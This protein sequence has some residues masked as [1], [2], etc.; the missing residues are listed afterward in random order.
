MARALPLLTPMRGFAAIIVAFYHARLVLF[1]QWKGSIA[2]HSAFLENGYIWVDLFFML[3]GFVMMHVY[4]KQLGHGLSWRGFVWLRFTRIYPLFFVSFLALFLWESF[5]SSHGLGF[6]GGPLMDAWGVTGMTAFQG[7]FNRSDAIV[8]NL[9]LIQAVSTHSLSWNIASWSLSVEWLVYLLFPLSLPALLKPAKSTMWI[10]VLI[11]V[12]YYSIIDLTGTLDLTAGINAFMRGLCGFVLGCWLYQIRLST[13][14]KKAI[15]NDISLA[16]VCTI[17]LVILHTPLTQSS[18]LFT[19]LSFAL[20]VLIGAHQTPRRTIVFSVLDNRAT[21]Y[22]GD[23][24]YSIYLWHVVIVLAGVELSHYL[25]PETVAAW[26][27]R[28]DTL[29]G[30]LGA[31][32]FIAMTLIISA[33]SYHSIERPALKLLRRLKQTSLRSVSQ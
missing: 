32:V 13:P 16:I 2:D 28:T 22:L 21:R 27:S 23:I 12:L 8:D 7:P 29:S 31:S 9:L 17:P 26:F 5:K 10:P 30:V 19:L 6:Y 18:I 15:D 11:F 14:L 4:R 33:L 1:P 24:S 3:S 25:F 20:V